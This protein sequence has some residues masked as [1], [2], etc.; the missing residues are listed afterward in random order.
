[1][2][3]GIHL[4]GLQRDPESMKNREQ[5]QPSKFVRHRGKLIGSRKHV[6]VGSR[7]MVDLIAEFYEVQLPRHARGRFLDLG[8]GRVPL[9]ATYKDLVTEVVCVDW[10]NT[11]HKNEHLDLECDLTQPLPLADGEFDT[12]LLS[13]VLEHIPEPA[14]L[15]S[16]MTR[17]LA[18]NGRILMNVPFYYWLHEQP[19][20][21]YRYTEFAL[22]RFVADS[23]LTLIHFEALGGAPEI[24]ADIFSKSLLLRGR[25]A[26]RPLAV[27]AQWFAG[28]FNRTRFGKKVSSATSECFPFGYAL[29]AEKPAG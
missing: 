15:W 17:I 3:G 8:C 23:G 18:P 6:S 25:R 26:G 24:M 16:E 14:G 5:W 22:R 27:F 12:I 9:Y 7:V 2:A 1:M 28:T 13:D 20:D 10:E 19:H 11:F 4:E 29:I 21:Y